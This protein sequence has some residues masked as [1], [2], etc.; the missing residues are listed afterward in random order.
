M[1]WIVLGISIGAA[2]LLA[3]AWDVATIVMKYDK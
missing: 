3:V 2:A 1:G